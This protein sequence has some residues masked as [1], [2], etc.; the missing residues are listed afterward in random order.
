MHRNLRKFGRELAELCF[1]L[2][3][4]YKHGELGTLCLALGFRKGQKLLLDV[5]LQFRHRIS[6]RHKKRSQ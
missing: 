5:V 4:H 6:V 2:V 3:V 1:P